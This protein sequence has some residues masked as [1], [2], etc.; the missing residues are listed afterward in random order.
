[1]K[2]QTCFTSEEIFKGLQRSDIQFF[3]YMTNDG[4]Y[5]FPPHYVVDGFIIIVHFLAVL[6][7]R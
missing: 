6:C 4:T 1:M 5:T 7:D 3:T 2:L